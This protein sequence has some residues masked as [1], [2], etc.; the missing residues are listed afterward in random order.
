[1]NIRSIAAS[2]LLAFI[3]SGCSRT[4]AEPALPGVTVYKSA[5]CG[6]CKLWVDR[7]RSAGFAVEARD[8]DNLND[9]KK[10]ISIRYGMGS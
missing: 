6:C 10:R 5:T 9:V 1:M 7:L 3:L 8:V 2:F 4:T